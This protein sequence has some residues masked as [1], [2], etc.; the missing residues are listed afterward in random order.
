LESEEAQL[1]LNL[2]NFK[3]PVR[4]CKFYTLTKGGHYIEFLTMVQR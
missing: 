3:F 1:N 4:K 2:I